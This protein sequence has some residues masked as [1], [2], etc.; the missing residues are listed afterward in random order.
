MDL[1]EG[2]NE[3]IGEP[4]ASVNIGVRAGAYSLQDFVFRDDLASCVDAPALWCVGL[5][6]T[7][8]ERESLSLVFCRRR[9]AWKGGCF[10]FYRF[11]QLGH[12]EDDQQAEWRNGGPYD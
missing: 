12:G 7:Y 10:M 11:V 8:T 2:D 6:S 4:S 5:H 1:L 3:V 9:T